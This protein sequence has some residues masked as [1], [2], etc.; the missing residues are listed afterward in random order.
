MTAVHGRWPA[1]GSRCRPAAVSGG[2]VACETA[3][4]DEVAGPT[5]GRVAANGIELAYETFGDAS[6]PPVVLIMGLATQ[7]I[8][9]PAEL[10]AGL[11]RSGLFVIR[12]DN[13]D[14]GG[15]THLR[16]VPP[17]RLAGIFVRR[18][19]P[20][21]SIGDM[22][23]DVVGLIDGLG[24]GGVHLVGASMGGFIAQAV[25][26]E[27][28]DRV[29]TLTLIMTS[30]GSRRVGH[31]RPRVYAR[32]LRSRVVADR[33]AA[34]SAVVETFRLIGSRG[35]AFDE[36]YLRDLA[37]RSWDRGYEPAG[38]RRQL[39]AA[40]RQPNRTAALR[41]VTV[42]TLVIHGLDDP[43]VAPSGG[44][45]IARAIPNS[46]FVGFSGMGHDLPRALWPE[47]VREIAAL[48]R[49]GEQRRRQGPPAG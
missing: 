16:D 29:R 22:A 35:F 42:P 10:C 2:L 14:V 12:F 37:G 49:L 36:E 13:R 4:M 44:L 20:P 48:A 43:L 45:A 18:R 46:R 19:P 34:M 1:A 26:L 39:A 41:R 6:A 23:G 30:T 25:A 47:F 38:Y 31:A 7:M 15:S 21:Y 3:L 33:A 9:W 28:A 32:L 24:L 11:A 5:P 8:A 40:A 17:P 27:H